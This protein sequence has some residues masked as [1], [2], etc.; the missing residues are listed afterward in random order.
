MSS[1]VVSIEAGEKVREAVSLM[2]S[3]NIGAVVVTRHGEPV[4]ILT[5]RDVTRALFDYGREELL[6]MEV[7]RVMSSPLITC[8]PEKSILAAFIMMYENRIRR[9]PIVESGRLVGIVTERDLLY[10][11]LRLIG[12]PSIREW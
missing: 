4:G 8:G 5:E 6:E 10:W 11:V 7:S 2:R 3:R 9:L 1:P 12:Y